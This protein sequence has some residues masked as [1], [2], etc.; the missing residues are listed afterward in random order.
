MIHIRIKV[1]GAIGMPLQMLG[2]VWPRFLLAS[3]RSHC[4]RGFHGKRTEQD[5]SSTGPWADTRASTGGRQ[6]EPSGP[7]PREDSAFSGTGSDLSPCQRLH[8][9]PFRQASVSNVSACQAV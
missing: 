7:S 1:G 3:L 8:G 9:Q 2:Q 4:C 5:Q 6:G